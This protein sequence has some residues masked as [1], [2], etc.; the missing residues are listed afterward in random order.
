MRIYSFPVG[1]LSTNCLLIDDASEL[2]IIDPGLGSFQKILESVEFNHFT[3][4]AIWLTHSHWDHT[5]DLAKCKKYFDIPVYVHSLDAGN[6]KKPGSD[7][8]PVFIPIEK[9][10]D[11]QL[12]NDGD[13]LEIGKTSFKVMHT[14]GHSPGGCCFYCQEENILISGDTLFAG[15]IGNLSLPTANAEKMWDSMNRLAKLNKKTK[16][17]PGHGESTTLEN[18]SWIPH[19]KEIFG[20]CI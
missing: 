9:V 10:E 4:K 19:A 14:P 12:I 13:I 2:V 6:V 1:P 8:L 17:Y 5:A 20:G 11:V 15:S 16:V 3:P 7:G 18:E